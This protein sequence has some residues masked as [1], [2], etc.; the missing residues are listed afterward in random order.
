MTIRTKTKGVIACGH[1]NTLDAGKLMF[2]EGG[3][4]FDALVSCLFASFVTEPIMNSAGGGGFMNAIL[5]NK[6]SYLLDFF[7]QT[8][9]VKKKPGDIDFRPIKVDYGTS[10]EEFYIGLGSIAT[11]GMLKGIFHIYEKF[12]SLPIKILSQPAIEFA[13]NGVEIN[14]FVALGYRLLKNMLKISPDLKQIFFQNDVVYQAGDIQKME[15]LADFLEHITYEGIDNFYRGDIAQKVHETSIEKGGSLSFDDLKNYEVKE[16]DGLIFSYRNKQVI[17]NPY[18]SIGGEML[19]CALEYLEKE[20]IH[21]TKSS[22]YTQT[23]YGALSQMM[24]QKDL[25]LK[26]FNSTKKGSTTQIS[27]VDDKGNALSTTVSN[28]E[29]SGYTI[30]GTGILLNNMLGESALLPNGFHS[31]SEN[32]RLSSMMTPTLVLDEKEEIEIITG[33][34][35]ASRIPSVITQILSYIIDHKM[36]VEMAVMAPR[37]HPEHGT[38][39]TEPMIAE[40]LELLNGDEYLPWNEQGMMFGGA[41]TIVKK[42]N[43]Y[44]GAADARR[45]GVVERI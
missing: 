42:G 9:L 18:P 40:P 38:L 41:H 5:P 34:G 8:P 13:K 32:K 17:T 10:S 1:Q 44:F 28:G 43:E 39:N 22:K 6:K 3:N 26:Q 45:L 21:D 2:E 33:T 31:W 12:C 35:G 23:V 25:L 36:D 30:P 29:G 4:A 27:I 7:C 15:V 24:K 19:K 16:L 11:P 20:K 14:E 37:L